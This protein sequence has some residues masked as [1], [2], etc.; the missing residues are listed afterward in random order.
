MKKIYFIALCLS[1]GFSYGQV[2]VNVEEGNEDASALLQVDGDS[3]GFG[4]PEINLTSINS[5]SPISAT[6]AE[7]L[8]VYNPNLTKEI[9]PGYYYWVLTPTPHWE[10]LGG[11]NEKGT[12]IQNIDEVFLG[13]SP[14]G[15]GASAPATIGDATRQRCAKWE[16]NDG[17]NGHVYCAYTAATNKDFYNSYE[18]AKTAGGYMVTVVSDAEWNFVKDNIVNDGLNLGGTILTNNIWLGYTRISTPG[19][20][21]AKYHFITGESWENRWSNNATTQSHFA[22][23]EP[24]M[25]SV[26]APTRC[27]FITRTAVDSQRLWRSEA[28]NATANM[29]HFIIEFNQ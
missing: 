23:S 11:I 2:Y 20:P 14:T 25:T 4:S 19:N 8:L 15:V 24:Q 16:I 3:Q 1:I 27:T 12:I 29:N 7:G 5:T 17:G 26:N 21:T 10:K 28:C 6:P 9:E 18:L 13:Y 22:A